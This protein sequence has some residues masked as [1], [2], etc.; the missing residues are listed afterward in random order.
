MLGVAMCPECGRVHIPLE[1]LRQWQLQFSAIT[2]CIAQAIGTTGSI[3][4]GVPNR[5]VLLGKVTT[6]QGDAEVFLARGLEW[7]DASAV[8]ARATRLNASLSPLLLTLGMP[9]KLGI[10]APGSPLRTAVLSEHAT[11]G[12]DGIELDLLRAFPGGVVIE[13]KPA[14][15]LR[16]TDAGRK[17]LQDVSGITLPQAKARV[18]KAANEGMIRTNGKTDHARRIDPISYDAWR[19]E[20]RNR[21]LAKYD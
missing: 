16:V 8:L 14:E 12:P 1:Q 9:P 21:E 5:I 10:W 7:D 19:L 6:P 4:E 11:L 15:W 3:V 2:N 17:L 20:Q 18:T 13:P